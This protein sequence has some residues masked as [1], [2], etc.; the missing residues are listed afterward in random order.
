VIVADVN[1][2][3]YLLIDGPFTA[4]ARG[5]LRRDDAWVAPPFWRSEFVNVLAT[6]VREGHF[7]LDQALAKL[8]VADLLVEPSKQ[9]ID[10]RQ[11][12]GLS[13]QTRVAT[14]DCVYVC[15]ARALGV[16]LVT[17]DRTVLRT[18]PNDTVSIE[19]FAAGA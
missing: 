15:L 18:F 14:Y 13:V 16:P 19:N 1:L 2:V 4:A 5:A 3:L 12:I 6:N 10:D 9:P 7:S 17:G 11:V 8:S